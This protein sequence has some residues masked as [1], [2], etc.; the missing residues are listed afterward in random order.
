MLVYDDGNDVRAELS[1]PVVFT[2]GYFVEYSERIFL[3]DDGEWSEIEL[4]SPDE[5]GED[6]IDID[7]RRKN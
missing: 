1:R 5:G 7:V 3:I 6:D 2:G 4:S